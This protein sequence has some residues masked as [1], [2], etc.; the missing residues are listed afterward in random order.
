MMWNFLVSALPLGCT[1]ILYDGNPLRDPS[2]LWHFVDELAITIF[3]TSAKY[4]EQLAKRRY[5]PNKHNRLDTLR[6]VYSTGSPLAGSGF[7][8]VYDAIAVKQGEVPNS[9]LLLASITGG[10]DICSLF[11]GFNSSLPVIRGEIQCRML[12]MA[13]AAVDDDGSRE[14]EKGTQGEL[15]CLRPFPC[16]PIGFWP[17][18]GFGTEEEVANAKERFRNAY[19]AGE[20][21]GVW[22]ECFYSP[23]PGLVLTARRSW[24]PCDRHAV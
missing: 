14:V 12:G 22:C 4:L 11:A 7:D 23:R 13:V 2:I 16:Q 20:M 1:L 9:K 6:H 5:F 24:G 18:E 17:L 21:K 15:V 8:F 3:G 19:F 10:T